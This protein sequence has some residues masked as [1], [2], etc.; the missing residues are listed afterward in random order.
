MPDARWEGSLHPRRGAGAAGRV[1]AAL[2]GAALLLHALTG[3]PRPVAAQQT[4]LTIS[5]NLFAGAP[6]QPDRVLDPG[7]TVTLREERWT[8]EGASDLRI[9][10]GS[11]EVAAVLRF[12][13][14]APLPAGEGSATTE[15]APEAPPPSGEAAS[16][17][18]T[19]VLLTHDGLRNFQLKS[20]SRTLSAQ[21]FAPLK[22]YRA[23]AGLETA[24]AGPPGR[25]REVV[26]QD[27]GQAELR[28][29]QEGTLLVLEA[30]LP[31]EG[32]EPGGSVRPWDEGRPL[33]FA[34][35]TLLAAGY[36][37]NGYG[38]LRLWETIAGKVNGFVFDRERGVL[39]RLVV[40]A[41]AWRGPRLSLWAEGGAAWYA[42]EVE[43]LPAPDPVLTYTGGLTL[44][45]RLGDWGAAAHYALVGDTSA[46]MVF[47]AWQ[48][49]QAWG[50]VLLWQSFE[51]R[52]AFGLGGTVDF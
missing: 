17:R 40:T 20:D 29:R 18:L 27:Q 50:L 12:S 14:L 30:L 48:A 51:D 6:A 36:T 9:V 1:A 38:E 8:A 25:V 21:G 34:D 42:A 46:T 49:G 52:S 32:G 15:G 47:G 45:G 26:I 33:R 24:L 41:Q 28:L 11:P 37:D 13:P 5:R 7:L 19:V 44:H 16:L 3:G 39:A 2:A 22:R 35:Y 43:G 31:A 10:A 23:G 4:V